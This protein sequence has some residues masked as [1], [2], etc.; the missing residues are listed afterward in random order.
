MG[1]LPMGWGKFLK[2]K[3]KNR[4]NTLWRANSSSFDVVCLYSAV[5]ALAH[6]RAKTTPSA[7]KN[8]APYKAHKVSLSKSVD[9]LNES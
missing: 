7:K 4:K 6:H 3:N 5:P 2:W 9:I 8:A 1:Q